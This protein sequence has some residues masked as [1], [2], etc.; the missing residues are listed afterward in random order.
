MIP[1]KYKRVEYENYS[2]IQL[3]HRAYSNSV[4]KETGQLSATD[5]L[6]GRNAYFKL[7]PEFYSWYDVIARAQQPFQL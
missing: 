7:V 2:I 1:E 6:S 3:V 5:T 4:K